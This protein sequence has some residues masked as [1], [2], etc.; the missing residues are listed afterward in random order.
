MPSEEWTQWFLTEDGWIKGSHKI[1][2]HKKVQVD[3]PEGW[4]YSGKWVEY[5]RGIDLK[6][7]IVETEFASGHNRETITPLIEQFGDIP[8][9]LF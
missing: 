7:S 4:V 9:S 3:P 5:Q 1:D 6:T 2:L 8:K